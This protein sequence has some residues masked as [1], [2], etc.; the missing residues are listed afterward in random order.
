M[1]VALK[2]NTQPYDGDGKQQVENNV[3]TF[4]NSSFNG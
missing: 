1:I 3:F 2:K 4:R